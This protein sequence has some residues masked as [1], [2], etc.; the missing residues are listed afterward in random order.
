MGNLGLTE[1]DAKGLLHKTMG[2]L[3]TSKIE[4]VTSNPSRQWNLNM[5]S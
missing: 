3:E 5:W 4:I 2:K 1:D